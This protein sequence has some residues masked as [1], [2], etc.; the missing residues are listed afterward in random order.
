IIGSVG[1]ILGPA[2]N[3]AELIDSLGIKAKLITEGKSKAILPSW[4]PWSPNEGE[5]LIPIAKQSYDVFLD[6]VTQARKNLSRE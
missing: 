3:F 4:T 1:V 6:I 5:E 2:F